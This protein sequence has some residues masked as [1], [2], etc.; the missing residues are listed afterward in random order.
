MDNILIPFTLYDNN[1]RGRIIRL[2]DQLDIIL[3]QHEYPE[4]ISR[5]LG[6]LLIVASLLG[7][8]FK[9]DITLSIQ[10]QT[11]GRLKYI[12]VDYQYP[13]NIRGY[14]KYDNEGSYKSDAMLS[15]TV[16]HKGKRYQAIVEVNN[17]N[18]TEAIEKYFAQSEQINTSLKLSIWNLDN[19]WYAGGILIQELPNIED[20][21]LWQEAN[22]LLSTVKDSELLNPKI[23]LEQLLYSVYHE[24][25]VRAF[26]KIDIIHKCRCSR[27]RA[28]NIIKSIDINEAKELIIDGKLSVNCQFCNIAQDFTLND[29]ENLYK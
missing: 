28:E 5:T 6:E 10:L 14:A 15:V 29:V 19:V 12:I 20:D 2:D 16:D 21:N 4:E 8:Q 13:G 26:D 25:K 7:S 17:M 27:E 24:A 1:I 23:S 11:E 9:D 18:I 22:I 3:K